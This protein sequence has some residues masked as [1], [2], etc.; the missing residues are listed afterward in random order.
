MTSKLLQTSRSIDDRR[1][2]SSA[3]SGSSYSQGVEAVV[4]HVMPLR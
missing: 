1:L 3:P 2:P 4:D